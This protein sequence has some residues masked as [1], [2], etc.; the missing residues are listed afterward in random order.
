M[1]EF[2]VN[3][4]IDGQPAAQAKVTVDNVEQGL[5]GADG[6]FSKTLIKKPGIEVEVVVS[7]EMP[8]HRI[9]PWKRTF[10]MK[11]PKSGT[12]DT[13]AFD[14]DLV[15]T[16]YITFTVTDKGG[17]VADAVVKTSGKELGKTDAQGVFVYEYKALPKSSSDFTV[18]KPGYAVW[19]KTGQVEPGQ[20]FEVTLSKRVIVTITALM[21]EY[22]QSSGLP[23]I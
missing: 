5:T 9:E 1:L 7:K 8:G 19:R 22:G 10:V 17:P 4:T 11:L 21:E 6:T 15:A 14:A 16:R 12:I 18:T 13:Y 23:G 2:K 20:K 3:A